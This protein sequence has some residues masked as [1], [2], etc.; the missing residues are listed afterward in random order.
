[1]AIHNGNSDFNL[2]VKREDVFGLRITFKRTASGAN[3]VTV[4]VSTPHTSVA[5]K[6]WSSLADGE[7]AS[8]YV[9]VQNFGDYKVHISTNRGASYDWY[10]IKL[11]LNGT[12]YSNVHWFTQQEINDFKKAGFFA[13]FVLT[14]LTIDTIIG[15]IELKSAEGGLLA[16]AI[17]A[18]LGFELT[19]RVFN[20]DNNFSPEANTGLRFK[21]IDNG[22]NYITC[23]VQ[24]LQRDSYGNTIVRYEVERR[25][26][27]DSF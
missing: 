17:F 26:Y 11:R 13:K 25:L 12:D 20:L 18:I 5:S 22:T 4:T 9:P 19:E 23:N 14:A 8:W 1:M 27:Y 24:K 21:L 2:A 6:T 7:V 15:E 16:K 3:P 10:V